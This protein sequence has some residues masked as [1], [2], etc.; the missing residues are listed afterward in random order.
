MDAK[1]KLLWL[2]GCLSATAIICCIA[3]G[4]SLRSQGQLIDRIQADVQ[5]IL[6]VR[7]ADDLAQVLRDE[8]YKE[9]QGNA[10]EKNDILDGIKVDPDLPD[11]DFFRPLLRVLPESSNSSDLPTGKPDGGLPSASSAGK[12]SS[13]R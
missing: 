9:A 10:R 11:A 5:I 13:D 1:G 4:L 3:L 8:L 6:D 7:K 12:T 2:F